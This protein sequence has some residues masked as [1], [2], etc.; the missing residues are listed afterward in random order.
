[1][2]SSIS[3]YYLPGY[4]RD[5]V[6]RYPVALGGGEIPEAGPE[7]G[8][9][10]ET[11]VTDGRAVR[12]G[13]LPQLEAVGGHQLDPLVWRKGSGSWRREGADLSR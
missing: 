1:M 3:V 10:Q 4:R 5:P 11:L 7:P 8:Q 13:Q 6:V 12:H 2:I 9:L